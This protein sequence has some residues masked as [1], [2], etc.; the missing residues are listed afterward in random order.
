M[1]SKRNKRR[2]WQS[3]RAH[4]KAMLEEESTSDELFDIGLWDYHLEV[5]RTQRVLGRIL[6]K[7]ERLNIW[8]REVLPF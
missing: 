3:Q 5:Y 6:S 7:Q 1:M 4:L 2:F 8:Y